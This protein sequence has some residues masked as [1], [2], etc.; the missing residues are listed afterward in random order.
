MS[1]RT[2]PRLIFAT[3][4]AGP[5]RSVDQCQGCA[6]GTTALYQLGKDGVGRC[7]HREADRLAQKEQA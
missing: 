5:M 1:K 6:R 4:G 7:Q 3:A 2:Y